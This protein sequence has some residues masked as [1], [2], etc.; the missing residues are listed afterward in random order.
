M[1]ITLGLYSSFRQCAPRPHSRTILA[2]ESTTHTSIISSTNGV[3]G[4][5]DH[6]PTCAYRLLSFP[7]CPLDSHDIPLSHCFSTCSDDAQ[8]LLLLHEVLLKTVLSHEGRERLAG[9]PPST[10]FGSTTPNSCSL[11]P[12]V[13]DHGNSLV[14]YSSLISW[15]TRTR[16]MS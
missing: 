11:Y 13:Q 7:I 3:Y 15:R 5:A 1:S 10:I 6:V 2:Y 9:D 12:A 14:V 8:S 16:A 4:E